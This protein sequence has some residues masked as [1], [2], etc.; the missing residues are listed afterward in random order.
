PVAPFFADGFRTIAY[1]RRGHSRSGPLSEFST[2]RD[3]VE[4]LAAL[5]EA[6]GPAPAHVI[7]HSFGGSIALKLAARRPEL[8][9]T[10]VVHEPPLF[11][12]LEGD[13]A[14]APMLANV[15]ARLR[16]VVAH[17]RAGDMTL[18][19]RVFVETMAFGPGA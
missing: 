17:L 8:I 15:R 18:G 6:V 5:I 12:L 19:A 7:G 13:P 4:D 3:D 11:D 1:D 10:M 2:T 16:R 9:R 14:L